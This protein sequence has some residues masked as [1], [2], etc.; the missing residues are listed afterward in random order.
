MYCGIDSSVYGEI[1]GVGALLSAADMIYRERRSISTALRKYAAL[2]I[3][4]SGPS[5]SDQ[6]HGLAVLKALIA[7][8]PVA[9]SEELY[10]FGA[11][12]FDVASH[13]KLGKPIA[14]LGVLVVGAICIHGE[15]DLKSLKLIESLES[16]FQSSPEYSQAAQ[17]QQTEMDEQGWD[18][19]I[20]D[21]VFAPTEIPANPYQQFRASDSDSDSESESEDPES[22]QFAELASDALSKSQYDVAYTA[23]LKAL[24][25]AQREQK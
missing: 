18:G 15:H 1:L 17:P 3:S 10:E 5:N 25:C 23:L 16:L 2:L 12:L 11:H 13:S 9:S 8:Q 4:S 14:E 22:V 21:S 6:I 7:G 24:E 20:P 19:K